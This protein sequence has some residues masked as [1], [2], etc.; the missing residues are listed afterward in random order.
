MGC[1]RMVQ[2]LEKHRPH[3]SMLIVSM[4]MSLRYTLNTKELTNHMGNVCVHRDVIK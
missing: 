1:L 2:E 4:T 3:L